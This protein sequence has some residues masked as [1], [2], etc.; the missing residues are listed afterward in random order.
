MRETIP[1]T[2]FWSVFILK[3]ESFSSKMA[4]LSFTIKSAKLIQVK[5]EDDFACLSELFDRLL[6]IDYSVY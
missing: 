1:A 2:N 5:A 6:Y 4:E 3:S